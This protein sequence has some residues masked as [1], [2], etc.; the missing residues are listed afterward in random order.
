MTIADYAK[1]YDQHFKDVHADQNPIV[2]EMMKV[3]QLAFE[4]GDETSE[5]VRLMKYE[6]EQMKERETNSLIHRM[7]NDEI[8]G[9]DSE[10]EDKS[11]QSKKNIMNDTKTNYQAKLTPNQ[12]EDDESI[13]KAIQDSLDTYWE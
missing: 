13:R 7:L 3:Q 10:D 4:A 6:Y 9:S 12:D 8:D 5:L 2:Q 1:H 11:K